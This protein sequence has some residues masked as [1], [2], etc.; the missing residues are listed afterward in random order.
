MQFAREVFI[1]NIAAG[2]SNASEFGMKLVQVREF[3]LVKNGAAG[4]NCKYCTF[5]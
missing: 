1:T 3:L 2:L 5:S 4:G